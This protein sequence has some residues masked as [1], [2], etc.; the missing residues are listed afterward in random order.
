MKNRSINKN[1]RKAFFDSLGRMVQGELVEIEVASLDVGEQIE[2]EWARLDGLTYDWK[3]D[4]LY[5]NT[6]AFEHSIVKPEE[7]IVV[8]DDMSINSVFVKDADGH[9]QS[10]KF[11]LPLMLRAPERQE[12][13]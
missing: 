3:E 6:P 12:H 13:P 1:E 4:I 8:Q 5:V 11:R 10:L 2:E 9:V 7:V